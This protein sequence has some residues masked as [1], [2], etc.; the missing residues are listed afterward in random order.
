V[1]LGQQQQT[2]GDNEMC[3]QLNW[4]IAAGSRQNTCRAAG[5]LK[6]SPTTLPRCHRV[7]SAGRQTCCLPRPSRPG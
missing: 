5:V 7:G 2:C 1:C 3:V 4:S 6:P